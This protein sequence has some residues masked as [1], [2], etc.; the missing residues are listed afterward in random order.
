MK[1]LVT[2]GAGFLGSHACEQ[3]LASGNSVVALD[4][5]DGAYSRKRKRRNLTAAQTNPNFKLVEGDYG[6]RLSV[7]Q[8][9]KDEKF[10]AVLHLAGHADHRL[11]CYDSLVYERT[12]VGNLIPFLEAL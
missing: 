1:I 4:N 5:F 3:L 7:T 10:D 6:D 2:G 9:L 12:N 8:L 11:S